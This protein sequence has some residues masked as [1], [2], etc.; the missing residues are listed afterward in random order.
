MSNSPFQ[1]AVAIDTNVFEHILYPQENINSHINGLLGHLYAEKVCLIVDDGNRILDEYNHR[2]GPRFRNADE[3]SNE[4]YLLRY[5]ILYAPKLSTSVA[6]DQLMNKIRQVI[7][8]PGEAVDRILVYVAFKQGKALISNDRMHIVRGPNSEQSERRHRI[9]RD[10]RNLRPD[11][12][13][14]VTS[15]EAFSMI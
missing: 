6:N 1:D 4:I 13:A 11:G 10:T 5:W 9:L 2:I 12:A 8:E 7:V 3:E 15:L 14:I